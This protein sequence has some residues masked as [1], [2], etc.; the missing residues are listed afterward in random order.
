MKKVTVTWMVVCL[1]AMGMSGCREAVDADAL[2]T[3]DTKADYPEKELLLQDF[4]EAEYVPLETTD[5]F[6]TQGYVMAVGNRYIVTKNRRE[7]GDIFVFDRRTGKG[8]HK[9]NRRGQGG[10]EYTFLNGAVLDEAR[11]E[12]YLN[13]AQIRKIQVYDLAGNFKRSLHFPDSCEFMDVYDFDDGHLIAYDISL[14]YQEGQP[15]QKPCYHLLLSKDDGRVTKGIPIAFET[16]SAP[17]VQKGDGIAVAAVCP[18]VLAPNGDWLLVETSTD[19]IYRYTP[20]DAQLHPFLAKLHTQDPEVM[21]TLG[22]VTDRYCFMR[23]IEKEFDFSTGGGFSTRVL[24]YDMQARDVFKP[25]VRNAD[26]DP[27]FS[28]SLLDYPQNR[29]GV[30][31]VQVLEAD[32]LVQAYQDGKLKGRLAEI[33]AR[34]HEESNPVVMIM[35][36]E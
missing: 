18:M 26:D 13:C 8:L 22:V 20:A 5:E 35:K 12:L 3:I 29:P 7:D 28:V 17:F 32:R 33:A 34:L 16:V 25:V 31:A 10:E 30:S 36:C 19:T 2:I 4:M 27:E 11:E 6:V 15:R 24:V 9:W 1:L 14:Y 23:T 21:L